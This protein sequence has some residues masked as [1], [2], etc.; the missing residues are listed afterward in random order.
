MILQYFDFCRVCISRKMNAKKNEIRG[1]RQEQWI[2]TSTTWVFFSFLSQDFSYE[3]NNDSFLFFSV[4]CQYFLNNECKKYLEIRDATHLQWKPTSTPWIFFVFAFTTFFSVFCR[5]S[6]VSGTSTIRAH[7]T[8]SGT[9]ALTVRNRV[10]EQLARIARGKIFC[11]F[12][13]VLNRFVF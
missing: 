12:R 10:F 9:R 4:P 5:F 8:I 1:G 13:G 6:T 7:S 3:Y 2:P 11:H